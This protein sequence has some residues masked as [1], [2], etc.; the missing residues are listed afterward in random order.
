MLWRIGLPSSNPRMLRV[1]WS[2][3]R[4]RWSRFRL[5]VTVHQPG[6]RCSRCSVWRILFGLGV[7]PS[8][9]Q[10]RLM[11]WLPES[12]RVLI[13]RGQHDKA[14]EVLKQ[15]YQYASPEIL[16]LKLR[17][18]KEHVTA[19]TVMQSSSSFWQRFMRL[20]THEPYCRSILTFSMISLWPIYWI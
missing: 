14:L 4:V 8:L 15:I 2:V 12:P 20:W 7:V 19:T 18:I 6:F 5:D 17:V 13:L 16:E 10:L 3:L 1:V 11:H 9:L